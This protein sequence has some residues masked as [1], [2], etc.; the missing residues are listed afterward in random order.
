MDESSI[1]STSSS[2]NTFYTVKKGDTLSSIDKKY[3]TTWQKIYEKNKKVIGSNPN[4]I[5]AGLKLNIS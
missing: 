1:K 3:N 5:E 2:S 4:I